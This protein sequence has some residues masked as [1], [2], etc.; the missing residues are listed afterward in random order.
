MID[1]EEATVLR[2]LWNVFLLGLAIGGVAGFFA[3]RRFE[4]EEAE[5]EADVREV[6]G[7]EH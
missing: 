7:P 1:I 2:A 4:R 6:V 3:G 5:I